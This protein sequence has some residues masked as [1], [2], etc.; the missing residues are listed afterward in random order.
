MLSIS[1]CFNYNVPIEEQFEIV[2]RAGFDCISLSSNYKHNG[3]FNDIDKIKGLMNTYNLRIDTI[4]GCRCDLEDSLE[5]LKQCANAANKLEAKVVVIHP[6]EFYIAEDRVQE[7]FNILIA[8]CKEL[9]PLAKELDVRFAIENLHPGFAT[10]VVKR[11]LDLLDSEY[12]GMCYDSSHDQLDGPRDFSL[13]EKYGHRVIAVHISDRIKEFVDHVVPEEG[14]IDFTKITELLNKS[15][16]K[17]SVLME[18]ASDNT[19]YK[20]PKQLVEEAYRKAVELYK[21]IVKG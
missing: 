8:V 4:H 1:T 18:V 5:R 2:Q 3:V 9:E 14:F 19:K 21:E 13:L 16:Y 10:E 6:C 17:G 20:E 7:K 11:A 12:F 15:A